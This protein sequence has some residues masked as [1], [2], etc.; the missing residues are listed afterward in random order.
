[1]WCYLVP[2]RTDTKWWHTYVY[3]FGIASFR[4]GVTVT[5]LPGR[6]KFGAGDAIGGTAN[7]APFPSVL[8]GFK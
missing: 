4:P 2:S 5:F 6:L 7:S 1:M 3:D 8:I